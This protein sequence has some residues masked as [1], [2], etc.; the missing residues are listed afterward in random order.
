[1][2]NSATAIESTLAE[3]LAAEE[4]ETDATIVPLEP[5]YLDSPVPDVVAWYVAYST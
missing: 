2:D 1:M 5:G 4:P 3:M